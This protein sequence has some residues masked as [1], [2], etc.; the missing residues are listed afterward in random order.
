MDLIDRYLAAV[1]RHLPKSANPD[2]VSELSDSLRSQAEEREA[3]LGRALNEDEQSTLLKPHGHPWL[4]ASRYMPQQYLIGPGLYPYYRQALTIV[5]FWVVLPITLLGGTLAAI[6]S[7]EP[8]QWF[9]RMLSA[10][11]NGAIYSMGIVT[12]VFAVLEHERVRFTAL[13]NWNPRRLPA[14]SHGR[15]I[16]RS[17]SLIGMVFQLAFLIWWTNV[18]GLPNFIIHN[19]EPVQFAAAPMWSGLYYP[20][21]LTVAASIGVSMVDLIRPWRTTAVSLIDI[22]VSL[23]SLAIVAMVLRENHFVTLLGVGDAGRLAQVQ[24]WVNRSIWWSFATVGAISAVMA[25]NEMWHLA[26]TRRAASITLA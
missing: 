15:E 19:G 8:G 17:E 12:L 2:I 26:R 24:H 3:Q 9:S 7:V 6:N 1:R 13:E 5:V 14:H 22:T 10:A 4:M 11:W 25:L 18:V 23:L 20:I 16:P 21:L